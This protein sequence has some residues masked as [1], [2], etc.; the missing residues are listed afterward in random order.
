MSFKLW[1][2]VFFVTEYG[3]CWQLATNLKEETMPA[4]KGASTGSKRGVSAIP[5]D[6]AQ[7]QMKSGNPKPTADPPTKRKGGK[8]SSKKGGK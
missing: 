2:M 3:F 4:K 5:S 7:E 8:K 6:Y 1:D